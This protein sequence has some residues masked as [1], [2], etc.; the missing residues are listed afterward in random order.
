MVLL[1]LSI[2]TGPSL[3]PERPGRAVWNRKRAVL[4]DSAVRAVGGSARLEVRLTPRAAREAV[5]TDWA[6]KRA[7]SGVAGDVADRRT[8]AKRQVSTAMLRVRPSS[9]A[10][11]ELDRPS[12]PSTAQHRA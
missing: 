6:G 4:K 5:V 1:S 3:M 12:A 11:A 2:A 8:T 10:T 7:S 9:W